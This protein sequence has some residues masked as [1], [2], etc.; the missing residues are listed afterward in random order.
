MPAPLTCNN[1]SVWLR[2]KTN[3]PWKGRG[4]RKGGPK[5]EGVEHVKQSRTKRRKQWLMPA[6]EGK[7]EEPNASDAQLHLLLPILTE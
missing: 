7:K 6:N 5:G 4:P 1:N 3:I 2:A